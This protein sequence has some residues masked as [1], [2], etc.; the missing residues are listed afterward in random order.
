MV[1]CI[2]L[3]CFFYP[4]YPFFS[5]EF[6]PVPNLAFMLDFKDEYSINKTIEIV[7][8]YDIWDRIILGK[9]VL[10]DGTRMET[11]IAMGTGTEMDGDGDG[12]GRT[13]AK[14]KRTRRNRALPF[15]FLISHILR[16]SGT[17]LQQFVG[18]TQA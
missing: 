8:A 15:F 6:L 10:E 9:W 3:F 16:V 5:E 12:D 17:I 7:K 14:G 1:V 2:V 13:G 11:G 4:G 18:F